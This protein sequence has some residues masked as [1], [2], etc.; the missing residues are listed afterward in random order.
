MPGGWHN[1]ELQQFSRI[2]EAVC[3]SRGIKL[4]PVLITDPHFIVNRLKYM[5][6]ALEKTDRS[7]E[8]KKLSGELMGLKMRV[9]KL[10]KTKNGGTR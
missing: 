9:G 1:A 2:A 6:D 4:P 3:K 10:F 8:I 5:A 7:D